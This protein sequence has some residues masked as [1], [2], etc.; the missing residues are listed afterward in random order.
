MRSTSIHTGNKPVEGLKA[1][2]S[3]S[4][5]CERLCP[6]SSASICSCLYFLLKNPSCE[7]NKWSSG[8]NIWYK[9]SESIKQLSTYFKT[10]FC[11]YGQFPVKNNKKALIKG[12]RPIFLYP[13][14]DSKYTF[15]ILTNYT[16]HMLLLFSTLKW[17]SPKTNTFHSNPTAPASSNS[18]PIMLPTITPTGTSAVSPG[19]LMVSTTWTEAETSHDHT[20]NHD[21]RVEGSTVTFCNWEIQ[22]HFFLFV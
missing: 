10:D 8:Y 15:V 2:H 16:N 6:S 4:S 9:N 11:G 7:G 18:P 17:L 14:T 3:T 21:H 13:D 5:T 12:T 22:I 1:A 19:L 20:S